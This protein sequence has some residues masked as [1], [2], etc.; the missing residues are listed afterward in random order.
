MSELWLDSRKFLFL[1]ADWLLGILE[2]ESREREIMLPNYL[3]T[4]RAV[5]FLAQ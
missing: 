3:L 2:R 1:P 4:G 5:S